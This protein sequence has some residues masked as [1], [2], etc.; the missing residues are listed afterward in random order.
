MLFLTLQAAVFHTGVYAKWIS[1]ASSTGYAQAIIY[2][3]QTRPKTD[4]N[5]ILAIGDSRMALVAKTANVLAP[6]TGYTFGKVA[7]GGGPPRVWY[8]VLRETDPHADRYQAVVIALDTYNDE[9]S[10]EELSGRESDL[11]YVLPYLTWRDAW[12]FSNSFP[13]ASKRWR[14]A[15]GILLKG[16]IY[17]QDFQDFLL[18]PRARVEQV[19][20]TRRMSYQANYDFRS[21][22]PSIAPLSVDW[23]ARTITVAPGTSPGIKEALRRRLVG[24]LPQQTGDYSRY[25][26]YWLG[27]IYEHY[28]GSNTRLVFLRVPRGPWIR[29]D[30]PPENPASSVRLLAK[31]PNV[32]LLPEHLFDELERPE[33]F[34]DELHMTQAGLDRFSEIL[35]REMPKVL[36]PAR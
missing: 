25:L 14:A 12:A 35:A 13:Q 8:Y 19:R 30:L 36:G 21:D 6:E 24:P 23:N 3:E 11:N 26:R 27:R 32:T 10:Y 28:R 34:H 16:S 2:D 29:P 31:H 7:M 18:N 33:L 5:Q 20:V 4:A 15:R 22:E 1:P 9:D 17:Q